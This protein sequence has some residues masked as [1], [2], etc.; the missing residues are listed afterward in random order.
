LS[1]QQKYTVP[2]DLDDVSTSVFFQLNE[3]GSPLYFP[4]RIYGN[5]SLELEFT[6]TNS[7]VDTVFAGSGSYECYGKPDDSGIAKESL[8]S[9]AQVGNVVTFSIEKDKIKNSWSQYTTSDWPVV[10]TIELTEGTTKIVRKARIKVVDSEGVGT[11]VA[12]VSDANE[13]IYTATTPADWSFGTEPNN[14]QDAVDE[15]ALAANTLISEQALTDAANIAWALDVRKTSTVIL[16]DDRILD[17]PTNLVAGA[18]YILRV[19]QDATGTR[20][21]TYGANYKWP[22]GTAPTLSTTANAIDEIEFTC[23]GTN[24]NGVLRGADFS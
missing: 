4:D 1:I 18:K 12:I 23:D 11:G 15:L 9:G 14:M 24:M 16:T 2:I 6:F 21:L 17:N 8:A 19:V 13:I 3:P 7:G 5:S 20:L 22:G 10:I